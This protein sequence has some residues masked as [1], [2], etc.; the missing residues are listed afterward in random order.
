MLEWKNSNRDSEALLRGVPLGVAEDWLH[1]RAEEM[2]QH[3]LEFIRASAQ[4]E[5]RRRR[6]SRNTIIGVLVG[7][8]S[9]TG[10]ALQWRSAEQQR[11]DLTAATA[12]ALLSTDPRTRD[13]QC[14]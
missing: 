13:G 14:N 7:A 1:K 10:F 8:F 2:T 12:K 6:R 4:Q 9:L 5:K 3:E 11:V